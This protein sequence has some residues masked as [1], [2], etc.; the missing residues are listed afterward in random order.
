MADFLASNIIW[1]IVGAVVLIM[2]IIGYFAENSELG[3]KVLG[4]RLNTKPKKNK[5]QKKLGPQVAEE[6]A[7]EEPVGLNAAVENPASLDTMT[8]S[9]PSPEIIGEVE[10][11]VSDDAWT[12]NIDTNIEK[13]TE[14]VEAN[15]NEWLDGPIELSTE[16]TEPAENI[17]QPTIEGSEDALFT[18]P[19]T[20]DIL[21]E[22]P[23]ETLPETP[24]SEVE[25]LEIDKDDFDDVEIL[26]TDDDIN[27]VEQT[28]AN[29][30]SNANNTA[31]V[32]PLN[33]NNEIAE[34]ASE[35]AA[36]DI[37]K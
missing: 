7:P 23:V 20:S 2:A 33:E 36:D 5:K 16:T 3:K 1:I 25:I 17:E 15:P 34:P 31:L 12:N 37:W 10:P 21:P 35:T 8:I 30:D 9:A 14:V 27:P 32:E 13:P 4:P 29:F 11:P 19:G 26:S 28:L 22:V 24:I 18:M 6:I